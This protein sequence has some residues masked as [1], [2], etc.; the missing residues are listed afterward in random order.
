MAKQILSSCS[1]AMP[2]E[3][4]PENGSKTIDFLRN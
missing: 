2:V 1:L 3:K 4:L